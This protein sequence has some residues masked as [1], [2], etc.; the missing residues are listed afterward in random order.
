MAEFFEK[1]LAA[2]GIKLK[3]NQ[4]SWPEFQASL[5]NKKGQMWG[6]AWGA[7]Y[8]DAENFLQ[9]F[10]S[11]NASPGPNDSNYSNPEFDRLYEKSLTMGDTPERT[12]L[13]KK[14]VALVVE[15]APWIFGVHRLNYFL[16]H[17]WLKNFKRHELEHNVAKYYRIDSSQRK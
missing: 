2:L 8:P 12:A 5:K 13:Y 6:F 9:L 14:M 7:D 11:K 16:V 4:Y 10:Y 3:V 17:P 1:S 15:D